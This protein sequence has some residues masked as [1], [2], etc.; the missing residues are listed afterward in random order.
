MLPSLNKK[1]VHA[2]TRIDLVASI[3]GLLLL[4]ACL[5]FTHW[6]ERGRIAHCARNM[7]VLGEAMQSF[8]SDHGGALPPAR[9]DQLGTTWDTELLPYLVSASIK[10][11]L[12]GANSA[13]A[14]REL[15]SADHS[16]AA[17]FICPSDTVMRNGPRTYAMP[18]HDL[19]NENWQPGPDNT[20]GVGLSFDK[21]SITTILGKDAAQKKLDLDAFALVKL[22]WISDPAN[23]LLLTELPSA[24][25]RAGLGARATVTAQDQLNLPNGLPQFH[26]GF[27]HYLMVDGHVELLIPFQTGSWDGS[28][29]IWSIKKEN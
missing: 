8:A 19:L 2:F 22:S 24:D 7:R 11:E 15:E 23:T 18:A 4:T 1:T 13:G 6:G 20:T 29:G 12:A 26:N 17:H 14:I 5:G 10:K 28:A 3:A 21:T 16:L 9:V 25:N 27:F